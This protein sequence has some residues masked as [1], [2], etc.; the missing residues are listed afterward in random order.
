MGSGVSNTGAVGV[1][2][3]YN[4]TCC[5]AGD[6]GCPGNRKRVQRAACRKYHACHVKGGLTSREGESQNTEGARG[7]STKKGM[8]KTEPAKFNTIQLT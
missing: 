6:N 2:A 8:N 7:S 3:N 1:E 4:C 5:E